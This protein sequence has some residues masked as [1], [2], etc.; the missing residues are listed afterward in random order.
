MSLFKLALSIA[1]FALSGCTAT[2]PTSAAFPGQW[3]P[4]QVIGQDRYI[5]EGYDTSA[6]IAG[7]TDYCAKM[8]KSFEAGEIVPHTRTDRATITFR[9]K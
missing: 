3:S 4:P 5:V 9:C 7:G 1:A 6:A 2:G 8:S